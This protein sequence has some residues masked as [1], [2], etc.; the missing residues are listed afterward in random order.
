[1]SR[2]LV[3]PPDPLERRLVGG[4]GWAWPT[5]LGLLVLA[6]LLVDRGYALIGD[7]VFVPDQPWKG[8]WLGLDGSVPRA[9][10]GDALISLATQVVPGDLLQKAVLLGLFVAAGVGMQRLT[11]GLRTGARLAACTLYVWNP[12]VYERLAIGHWALL[13]G[14]AALPWVVLGARRLRDGEPGALP[15]VVLPV[16]VAAWTSPTGGVLAAS[17][18]LAVLLGRPRRRPLATGLVACVALNLPW[19]VPGALSTAEQL[20]PDPFGVTAFAA[21]ADTPWGVLGSLLSF[22]GMWK[23]S[24]DPPGRDSW[25]LSTTGLLLTVVALAGLWLALR[26]R[27][28][29]AASLTGLG[30]VGILLSWLPATGPGA[31]VVEWLVA[32]APGAGL[33]R[34]SQKWVALFVLAACWGLAHLVDRVIDRLRVAT[35]AVT[36]AAVLLPVAALPALAW[37]L[38]GTLQPVAYPEEWDVVRGVLDERADART[39]VLP[40]GIYRRF[41]WNDDRAL[42]DP[43]PR[44]FRGQVITDDALDVEGGTV[45]GESRTARRITAAADDPEALTRVLGEEDVRFVVVEK[46]TPGRDV[47]E[48]GGQVLH[49]GPELRLVDLGHEGRVREQGFAPVILVAD[50]VV[51]LGALV[52]CGWPVWRRLGRYTAGR[53]HDNPVGGN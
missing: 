23:A 8:A 35:A 47:P 33:L 42:L 10:P 29:L 45:A 4:L 6:P 25:L 2:R 28:R 27:K 18:A 50:L 51:A 16:A 43:A 41:G 22:G 40:F 30:L 14:Y 20:A 37:G 19:V 31:E 49:D 13:C 46:G 53:L 39:V 48:L 17:A 32:N 12:F 44:Y 15:A 38:L 26:R 7:M 9:V 3:T 36:A 21:R 11:V 34:D 52:T 5:L 1:M 24:V